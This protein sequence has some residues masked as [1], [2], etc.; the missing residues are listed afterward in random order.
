MLLGIFFITNVFDS[1][2]LSAI[3]GRE[4]QYSWEW[5][6]A[7]GGAC[8]LVGISIRKDLEDG[9]LLES[10]GAG[11]SSVGLFVYTASIMYTYGTSSFT[12]L[13]LLV[14]GLG[15]ALRSW[16]SSADRRMAQRLAM[17]AEANR[18]MIEHPG[19][20]MEGNE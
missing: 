5:L 10:A 13:L 16:Q 3:I 1:R 15:C 4:W 6:M 17:R 12:W 9:L 7:V 18:K 19:R 11:S 2:A 14:L 8:G 20:E